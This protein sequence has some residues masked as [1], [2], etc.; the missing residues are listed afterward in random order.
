MPVKLGDIILSNELLLDGL[1]EAPDVAVIQKRTVVG[2]SIVRVDP[3]PG[4]RQLTL[5]GENHV[6]LEQITAIKQLAAL[7]QLVR[8]EH[9]RG[10]F[11]V[12]IIGVKATPTV[13]YADPI[14]SDWYSCEILT[15]EG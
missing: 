11:N 6:T 10:S 13:G 7:G 1:E 15:I 8:L 3:T 9:H 14:G 12:Y 4:G 5:S 2:R